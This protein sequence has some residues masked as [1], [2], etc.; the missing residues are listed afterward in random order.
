MPPTT[1]NS[2]EPVISRTVPATFYIFDPD[3]WDKEKQKYTR[4]SKPTWPLDN[5]DNGEEDKTE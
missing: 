1:L 3:S 4:M 2:E 5:S